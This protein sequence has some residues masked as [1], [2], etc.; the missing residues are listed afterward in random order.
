[1]KR[2]WTLIAACPLVLAIALVKFYRG[3]SAVPPSAPGLAA[4]Q[5][6]KAEP[7]APTVFSHSRFRSRDATSRVDSS[8]SNERTRS[9]T[10][11]TSPPAISD[12]PSQAELERRAQLVERD[13]N[14]ELARLIPLLD[15]APDQQER[16]FQALAATSPYFVPGMRVDGSV[17]K[18]STGNV[19]QTVQSQLT[20]RQVAAY[21]QDASDTSAWWSEYFD[22]VSSL[23]EKGT[24]SISSD[25]G[26]T[27][28]S[29]P[30][31]TPATPVA[32]DPTTSADPTPATKAAHAI[33]G[34]E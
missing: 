10:R 23:L 6:T 34:D 28:A 29:T 7:F 14:H 17:L 26:A 15:L 30:T 33:T 13:A 5:A 24:P 12:L 1:M 9:L 20:D 31:T 21:L 16:V 2:R 32:S 22:H 11:K 25:T 27:V 19:Q 8:A 3:H 4:R 18:P